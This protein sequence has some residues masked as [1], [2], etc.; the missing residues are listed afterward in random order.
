MLA[1]PYVPGAREVEIALYSP[2]YRKVVAHGMLIDS[3]AVKVS[4]RRDVVF[5]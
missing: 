4:G 5:N 3:R 2:S 1:L